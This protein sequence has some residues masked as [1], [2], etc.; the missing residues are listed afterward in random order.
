MPRRPSTNGTVPQ[1]ELDVAPQRP[2]REVQVVELTI[3]ESGT[4]C[5]EPRIC[6]WPVIPGGIEPAPVAADDP[7]ILLGDQRPRPDQAH[8]AAQHV[9]Q[10]GSSST[11][12]LRMSRPTRVTRGSA[13]SLNRPAA[14]SLRWSSSSL[15]CSASLT[16]LR[17]FSIVNSRP[18]RPTRRWRNRIGPGESR[19]IAIAVT[20][21]TG[22]SRVSRAADA[23][24]SKARLIRRDGAGDLEPPH[25]EQ[26]DTVQ[27]VELDRGAGHAGRLGQDAHLDPVALQL[28][29]QEEDFV[30][31]LGVHR[32]DHAVDALRGEQRLQL[33]GQAI[34]PLDILG[35]A[36]GQVPDQRGLD[37]GAQ[38]KLLAHVCGGGVIADQQATLRGRQ[39]ASHGPGGGALPAASRTGSARTRSPR[40]VRDRPRQLRR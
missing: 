16:M 40:P 38:R 9:D 8:L 21:K 3:S 27:V 7:P 33:A 10:L 1:Q 2:V 39:P 35:A 4:R 17:N 11:W 5:D 22:A 23:V 25:P 28:A 36:G 26:G 31:S 18:C 37:G 20:A 15:S 14:P 19:R 34:R 24:T 30:A 29:D 32:E 13:S 12:V 6:Q